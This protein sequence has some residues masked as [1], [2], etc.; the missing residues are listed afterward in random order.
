VNEVHVTAA[1]DRVWG[2]VE[3][4]KIRWRNQSVVIDFVA[5]LFCEV[6]KIKDNHGDDS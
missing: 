1:V 3:K 4:E 2:R 6:E 5:N